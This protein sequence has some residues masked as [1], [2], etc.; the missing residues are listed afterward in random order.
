MSEILPRH[1]ALWFISTLYLEGQAC[2]NPLALIP[3]P[4]SPGSKWYPPCLRDGIELL[5]VLGL[6]VL[7]G[8]VDLPEVRVVQVHLR[9]G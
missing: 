9:V 3:D 6:R 7:E 2:T 4:A 5:E 1:L 8:R